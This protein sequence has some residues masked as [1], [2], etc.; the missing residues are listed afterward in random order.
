MMLNSVLMGLWKA[1]SK[2]RFIK[3][4]QHGLGARQTPVQMS[5]LLFPLLRIGVSP[6]VSRGAGFLMHALVITL[7][8]PLS[9]PGSQSH[10]EVTRAVNVTQQ[11]L[12]ITAV[13]TTHTFLTGVPAPLSYTPSLATQRTEK[14]DRSLGQLQEWMLAFC[15]LE[16]PSTSA[17]KPLQTG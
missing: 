5:A 9:L 12:F 2:Q 8:Q 15:L 16:P 10:K 7:Q 1:K 6:S 13:I 4:T 3:N 17:A 11:E 14:I